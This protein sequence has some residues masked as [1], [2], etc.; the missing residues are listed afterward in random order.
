MTSK[1]LFVGHD[2]NGAGAQIVLL[3]WLKAEAGRGKKNYLLLEKGG[4]LL[5]EYE[6]YAKVWVWRK[7]PNK[8][9]KIVKKIPF[10]KRE[11]R[12]D[13]EP[14]RP[15]IASMLE[16]FKREKF[17]L[18]L[19]NTV[20]SLS[21]LQQLQGM[22]IPFGAYVHELDFSLTMYASEKD[23][24]FLAQKVSLVFGV[25]EQVNHLLIDKFNV[26]I[27]R[28]LLL[29]PI[30]EIPKSHSDRGVQ[31]R[32]DL[33]I[34]PDAWV[35]LGCGLAEWRKGTDI[36]IRVARQVI[37]K[38]PKVHFIWLGVG[39]NVFSAE[40][41]AEKEHWDE[42]NQ[43]HLIPRKSDSKPYFEAMDL[44]FL[45][46]REDPFPLVM[47]EAAFHGKP[48]VGF[49][50]SGGISDFL[51]GFPDMLVGYLEEEEARDRILKWLETDISAQTEMTLELK[52]R[53]LEYSAER[54][55]E[56]WHNM[57]LK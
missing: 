13:R 8:I 32:E 7:G 56:R 25:S 44:F 49:K 23:M 21:L 46:S 12:A 10:L 5:P 30:I 24:H 19:G 39:D 51:Q 4:E 55:L 11:D 22:K 45:S 18:I 37:R 20:A 16:D 34:P 29:P 54:F 38:M 33:G 15:E 48:I 2:A 41:K 28:T 47:L 53:S 6:R 14:N 50:G 43:V 36:F 3:N 31:V 35:V 27:E 9:D 26:P 52:N 57:D 40:L 42:G 17:S 1:I